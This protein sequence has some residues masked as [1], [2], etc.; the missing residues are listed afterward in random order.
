MKIDIVQLDKRLPLP[1]YAKKGDAGL[2]LYAREDMFISPQGQRRL[3]PTG[4]AV[5]IPEG[6]CGLILPRSGL[7]AKHGITVVNAPGLIDSG[8]RGE[9]KIILANISATGYQFS[10]GDRVAQLMVAPFITASWNIVDE[11]N[12][13]ERA[14]GGIGHTGA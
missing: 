9:I 10:R 2:D 6:Y 13:T 11:L 12:E 8:Y 14:L 5:A 4:I 3:M 1:S 7:A